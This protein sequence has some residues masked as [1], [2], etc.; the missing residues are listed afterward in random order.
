M[1]SQT[2][3]K[4]LTAND[5]GETGGH[6]AGIHIPKSQTDLIA[7]L[8]FLDPAQKNPDAWLEMTDDAGV[9][10]RFRYIYYNNRLHDEGGTRDEYR[11]THMTKFFRAVGATEGDVLV[12]AGSPG[13][14]TYSVSVRKDEAPQGEEASAPV[15]V[16]LKGWR[17]VH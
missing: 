3:E 2:Y 14:L 13:S 5:T 15:R 1:G 4:P 12:L 6:Q 17:R 10:W 7:L 16:R 9:T 8:P 11:I